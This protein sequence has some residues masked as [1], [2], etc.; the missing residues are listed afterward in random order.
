MSA[1]VEFEWDSRELAVW[2]GKGLEIALGRAMRSAGDK[3]I[4]TARVT[5]VAYVTGRKAIKR[6]RAIQGIVLDF[7]RRGTAM[8]D[9][10]WT[11]RMSGSPMPLSAF[12]SMSGDRGLNVRVN[13][14]GGFKQVFG[15]FW[16]RTKSGHVGIFARVGAARLPIK[17]LWSSTIADTMSDPGA[18]EQAQRDAV[19]KLGKEFGERLALEL[20]KVKGKIM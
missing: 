5:S 7:P 4:R 3:A 14:A 9:M 11:E 10:E 12:P 16:A 20:D 13:T 6:K 15:S 8:R 1:I 19:V 17:E 18:I 2:R